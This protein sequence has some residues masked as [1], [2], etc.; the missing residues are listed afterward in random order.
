VDLGEEARESLERDYGEIVLRTVVRALLKW[1]VHRQAEKGA[2]ELGGVLANVLG[3]ATEAAETRTW[4]SLPQ[5]IDAALLEGVPA[6]LDRVDL[7]GPGVARSIPV[8]WLGDGSIGIAHVR[9]FP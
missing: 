4:L 1:A 8:R 6:T 7:L 9:L 2:G 3:A 5:E